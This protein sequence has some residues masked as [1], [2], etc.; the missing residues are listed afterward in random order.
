[1]NSVV[2]MGVESPAFTKRRTD[3]LGPRVE[4]LAAILLD[5][6]A[7]APDGRADLRAAYAHPLPMQVICERLPSLATSK[8]AQQIDGK[9]AA[10]T[11]ARRAPS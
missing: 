10:S 8:S 3:A 4:E 9:R 2:A 11:E 7:E 5:R 1:M 6:M